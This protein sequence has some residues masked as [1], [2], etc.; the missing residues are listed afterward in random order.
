MG[1]VEILDKPSASLA[2]AGFRDVLVQYDETPGAEARLAFAARFA[3][4][5]GAHLVALVAQEP[6]RLPSAVRAEVGEIFFDSWRKMAADTA[7]RLSTRVAA[8]ARSEGCAIECRVVEGSPEALLLLHSRYADVTVVGQADDNDDQTRTIEALLFGSGRPI[9]L[10]PAAGTYASVGRNVLCAWNGSREA[11]R[12]VADALPILRTARQ[13]TVLSADPAGTAHRIPGADIALHLA[14]HGVKV[15][16]STTYTG[17]L[18]IGDALLNRAADLG[19]DLL[20]M[21][22]YGHSRTR[23]AFFGGATRHVLDHMTLPVFMSH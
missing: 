1:A 10:V 11:T 4:D 23:E 21:G 8:L 22:G 19:A 20:V 15:T 7:K 14:R 12:A 3:R 17:E 13:V 18:V 5:S 9:L 2:G 16:S 6:P